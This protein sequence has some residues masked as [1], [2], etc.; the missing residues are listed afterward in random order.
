MN[1]ELMEWL[2]ANVGKEVTLDE[3]EK[4]RL[5]GKQG[6]RRM[7]LMR[8]FLISLTPGK[9]NYTLVKV[10]EA[11]VGAALRSRVKQLKL[12][13]IAEVTKSAAATG[14]TPVEMEQVSMALLPSP[15][16]LKLLADSR[17]RWS[18]ETKKLL[19]KLT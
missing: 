15:E 12:E 3:A 14:L 16:T 18:P 17:Q 13:Y 6:R 8:Q 4:V 10:D 19:T 1:K 7:E 5:F 11:A 2:A 9:R